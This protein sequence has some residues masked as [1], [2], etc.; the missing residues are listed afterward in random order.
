ME[1]GSWWWWGWVIVMF[2]TDTRCLSYSNSLRMSKAWVRKSE[3]GLTRVARSSPQWRRPISPQAINTNNR[4]IS[5]LSYRDEW[6]QESPQ[7]LCPVWSCAAHN[8][9]TWKMCMIQLKC[10][11]FYNLSVEKYTVL[12]HICQPQLEPKCWFVKDLSVE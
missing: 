10:T 5:P 4:H 11:L 8:Y 3:I 7:A 9:Y 2:C 1:W 6:P 12:S